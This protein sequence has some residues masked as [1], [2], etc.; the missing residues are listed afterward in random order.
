MSSL[1]I[2]H[3]I[4]LEDY[5]KEYVKSI[6]GLFD[7]YTASDFD[8]VIQVVNSLLTKVGAT[9]SRDRDELE[10]VIAAMRL[11]KVGLLAQGLGLEKNQA[12]KENQISVAEHSKSLRATNIKAIDKLRLDLDMETL[13]E[14]FEDLHI[15]KSDEPIIS[16]DIKDK[17]DSIIAS[18]EEKRNE[19]KKQ[20]EENST[21]GSE[22][23]DFFD[24]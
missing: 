15:V 19:I 18:D 8:V 14:N 7:T 3:G 4:A 22:V 6:K 5:P 12:A 10:L 16:Q 9:D 17:I 21:F 2:K 13:H 23:D 20:S 11:N 1:Y 24:N